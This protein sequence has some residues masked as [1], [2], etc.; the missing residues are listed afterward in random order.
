[1]NRET[2]YI[3]DDARIKALEQKIDELTNIIQKFIS[4]RQAIGDWLNEEQTMQFTGL[5]KTKLYELR[6]TGKIRSS[7]LTE[8]KIFYRRSDIEKLLN[9]NQT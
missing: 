9:R 6:N 8:R 3:S 4:D 7:N 5:G 1:M 2:L